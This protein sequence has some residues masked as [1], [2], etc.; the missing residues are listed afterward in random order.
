MLSGGR[1]SD[2]QELDHAI[3]SCPLASL[4][5]LVAAL[6]KDAVHAS[7]RKMGYC[8]GSHG[9]LGST[10]VNYICCRFGR[11]T[12]FDGTQD[13]CDRMNSDSRQMRLVVEVFM[14]GCV[15]CM[16][17]RHV[18]LRM[19]SGWQHMACPW[20]FPTHDVTD[21]PNNP[22]VFSKGCLSCGLSLHLCN[23]PRNMGVRIQ[24]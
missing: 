22:H 3:V 13:F 8:F 6:K 17:S 24:K 21:S 18:C 23:W 12:D 16:S 11:F 15:R 5:L 19:P 4:C 9:C 14:K 10:L 2:T 7:F 20:H 1:S